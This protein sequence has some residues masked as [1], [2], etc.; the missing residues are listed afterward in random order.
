[1]TI[2]VFGK[3][4]QVATALAKIDRVICFG[5]DEA[6]FT[7]PDQCVALLEKHQPTFIINAAAYTAVDQ[8]EDDEDLATLI[9]AITPGQ[10]AT[11]AASQNIPLIHISTDYVFDG[12]GD[13]PIATESPI[14]PLG[15]YGRSKAAGEQLI[16][17]ANGPHAIIRTS[18]IFSATG[19]NFVKTMLQLSET[20]DALTVVSDQIGGPTA[21][22]AI[23]SMA[24]KVGEKLS[25]D[26]G[27]SGTYH[28]SGQP[29]VSWADFA[30]AIFEGAGKTVTVTDIP[31]A[32][33]PTKAARP[34][35]SRLDGTSLNSHFGI[36][37]A[38]WRQD[39][40]TVITQLKAETT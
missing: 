6:D 17:D 11:Y 7:D 3:S 12:C 36:A 25:V 28:F 20:R 8:A 38:N 23:A 2:L 10:I 33:Y 13:T 32:D 31:S 21:A 1:M 34:L 26:H 24:V 9:N 22:A 4:G 35:N 14:N 18:W 39:L 30:R 19:S 15:A 40:A 27:L 29:F 16:R 37:P 5:R